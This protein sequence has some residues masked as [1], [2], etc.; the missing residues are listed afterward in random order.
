MFT[1]TLP[2]IPI[3]IIFWFQTWIT[4]Q[5]DYLTH[6]QITEQ[7][8]VTILVSLC[9]KTIQVLNTRVFFIDTWCS[10]LTSV[11]Y[12]LEHGLAILTENFS[13]L[14]LNYTTSLVKVGIRSHLTSHV[15]HD[16]VYLLHALNWAKLVSTGYSQPK[17][18]L[19]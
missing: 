3:N 19:M 7:T 6:V 14:N 8:L 1:H 15:I 17:Q 12:N 2:F 13:P 16:T 9:T 4:C 11:H 18:V 5:S 10:S